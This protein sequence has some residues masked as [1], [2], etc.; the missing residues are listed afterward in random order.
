M[1]TAGKVDS[2]SDEACAAKHAN[3]RLDQILI[4]ALIASLEDAALVN[5]LESN[6][7]FARG[8]RTSLSTRYI[9]SKLLM[10]NYSNIGKRNNWCIWRDHEGSWGVVQI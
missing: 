2:G 6:L 9:I 1:R 5:R 7:N 8:V 3:R 4:R 10:T